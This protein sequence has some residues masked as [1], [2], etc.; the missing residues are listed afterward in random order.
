METERPGSEIAISVKDLVKRFGNFTAVDHVSFNVRRGEI[1]G[2]L[3][4]NGS[5]KSTT[6]RMLCGLLTPTSGRASVTGYDIVRDA[7]AIQRNIGYMSQKFSLY[8]DLTVLENI[9]FYAGVYKVPAERIQ[10]RI[11]AVLELSGLAGER[12]RITGTLSVGYKQRLALGCAVV[13]EPAVLFLDEPTSGVDP[14]S[15]RRF[16]DLIGGLAARGI[17]VLVT[18]H[19]MQEAEYCDRLVMIYK[20]RRVALGTPEELK[21]AF[22]GQILEVSA[23]PSMEALRLA[24]GWSDV[25]D[26]ALFGDR[27][28]ITVAKENDDS[29]HWARRFADAGLPTARVTPVDPTLEDVFVGLVA[30]ADRA[31][32]QNGASHA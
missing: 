17:S 30:A 29:A 10:E 23:Q 2:F 13:H 28:H 18:T 16:W 31:E 24:E 21:R 4:P 22:V 15:R 1:F 3:G 27:L 11:N 25:E 5:G 26:A 8:A 9:A 7:P 12:N 20:G 6:I 14:V 19:V 32:R